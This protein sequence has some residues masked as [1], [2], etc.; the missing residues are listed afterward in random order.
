MEMIIKALLWTYKKT[1]NGE[2]EIR[3]R[4]TAYKDV[5]YIGLGYS[6]LP[7]HWDEANEMPLPA[8]P[9][10]KE[11]VKEIVR[12]KEEA[13]FELRL[14]RKAHTSLTPAEL[15]QKLQK[16]RNQSV[17]K[18]LEFFDKV[19]A[20]LEKEGR[21]GYANVF[22]HCKAMLSNFLGG[23]DKVFGTFSKSDC[24]QLEKYLLQNVPKESSISHYLRT[25][26]RLWNLAV[27]EGIAAKEL[28]P[29]K[30]IKFKVYR[31]FK[32]SKR[33]INFEYIQ[34][35]ENLQFEL[36]SRLYRS[37]QYFL[38]SYYA[39]GINFIDLAQLKDKVHLRGDELSYVRSK[40][41]RAYNFKLHSKAYA[42]IQL[43]REYPLQSD[44]DYLFPILMKQHDTPKKIDVR[45]DSA[46][47]D[48]NEDLRIMAEKIGLNKHLTSYVARHSFA[49]NLRSKKVDVGI[50]QGALGHE[51]E[52]QTA[53][54]LEE[55]DDT[56]VASQIEDALR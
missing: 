30:Y 3:L 56:L 42:I 54:Y 23:K 45:I 35:I 32:T 55:I 40:N 48:L 20:D 44:G 13:D 43:F 14:A 22:R 21:I 24:E 36:G 46:L 8:H 4:L 31:K 51:T 27:E 7:E 29:S 39:R 11:I 12:L 38:F 34:A 6:S 26:Y 41:K 49:S 19:I 33:A 15:K 37:Q 9:R 2:H 16:T 17:R 25:F 18:I 1:A 50:I 10:F 5:K 47:K 28:H 53:V 52:L